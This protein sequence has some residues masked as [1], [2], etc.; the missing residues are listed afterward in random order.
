MLSEILDGWVP[1]HVGSTEGTDGRIVVS[2][3][4]ECSLNKNLTLCTKNES[5]SRDR[6][7]CSSVGVRIGYTSSGATEVIGDL[8]EIFFVKLDDISK[9]FKSF[10]GDCN[11]GRRRDS[12]I[13]RFSEEGSCLRSSNNHHSSSIG[14]DKLIRYQG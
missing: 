1:T 4:G 3:N 5:W 14:Y 8:F 7:A 9:V 2:I 10:L 6:S 12:H 11:R 13:S